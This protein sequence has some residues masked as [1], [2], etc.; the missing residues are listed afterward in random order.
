M[1][2]RVVQKTAGERGRAVLTSAL[3]IMLALTVLVVLGLLARP[4]SPPT[5]P[6]SG[7]PLASPASQPVASTAQPVAP[8]PGAIP[9]ATVRPLEQTAW[10]PVDGSS[11]TQGSTFLIRLQKMLLVLALVSLLIWVILRLAAPRMAGLANGPNARRRLLNVLERHS[12]GPGR[13]LLLVE[14]AGRYLLLGTSEHGVQTLAELSSEEIQAARETCP[15]AADAEKD[16]PAVEAPK[17][18]VREV[19]AQHLSALPT[20]SSR[21]RGPEP[22]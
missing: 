13:G 16:R 5:A 14:A 18:L 9:P 12:L 21:Q 20:L 22:Q 6:L 4:H 19:L 2:L 11:T 8:A 15:P 7:A 3:A 10:P 1:D 17:N